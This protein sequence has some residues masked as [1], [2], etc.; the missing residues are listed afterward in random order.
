M[1]LRLIIIMHPPPLSHKATTNKKTLPGCGDAL[2]SFKNL[3]LE[4][5]DSS[6]LFLTGS[7]V[8]LHSIRKVGMG[9]K[10]LKAPIL[11]PMDNPG[12]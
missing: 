7:V 4:C 1:L 12:L 9:V 3:Y 2:R 8:P 6:V 5:A 10:A 11:V